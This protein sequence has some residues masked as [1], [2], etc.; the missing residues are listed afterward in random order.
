MSLLIALVFYQG[1]I[2][3]VAILFRETE[4]ALFYH[5]RPC[6]EKLGSEAGQV[7]QSYFS[8]SGQNGRRV[9]KA[10]TL[11]SEVRSRN[12]RDEI[13]RQKKPS[14]TQGN[15]PLTGKSRNLAQLFPPNRNKP[16]PIMT[17]SHTISTIDKY[18]ES[19][20]VTITVRGSYQ[21]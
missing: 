16:H 8:L 13:N 2:H 21:V 11:A 4:K 19:H 10:H 7:K 9:T 1:L 6:S 17:S 18:S 20:Q 12:T 3:T 14:G 15:Y 5:P